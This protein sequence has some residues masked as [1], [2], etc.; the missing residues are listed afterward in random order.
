MT[1]EEVLALLD[2]TLPAG[3]HGAIVLA[4]RN[5]ECPRVRAMA[6]A[7]DGLKFYIGTARN[8]AKARD[9]ARCPSIEIIRLL[10]QGNDTGRLGRIAGKAVEVKGRPSTTLGRA[11]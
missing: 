3:G 4:T 9:I 1:K 6:V 2:K 5:G 8:S 7:R 10:S 11:P